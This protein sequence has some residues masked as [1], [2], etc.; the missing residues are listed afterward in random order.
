MFRL[1]PLLY[2]MAFVGV[3]GAAVALWR[4]YC[5]GFGCT[6]L[7]I[8]WFMWFSV[9]YVPALVIGLVAK[10]KAPAVAPLRQHVSRAIGFQ[11]LLGLGL[12][13]YWFVKGR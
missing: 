7:G 11:L 13:T 8:A 1:L 3:C 6:G 4:T 5:E 10:A 12:A 2:L 9:L